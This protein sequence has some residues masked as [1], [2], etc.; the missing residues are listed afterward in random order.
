MLPDNLKVGVESIDARHE[1]FYE[2]FENL[3]NA[4]DSQFLTKF[5]SIIDHTINH[6]AEEEEGLEYPNRSEHRTEHIK[7]LEEMGYFYEKA[8]KGKTVFARAY[9]KEQLGE[10]FRQHLLNMDSD[11]A[12]VKGLV[13]IGSINA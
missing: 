8:K 6:F 11:L 12:R 7:A 5:K 4:S 10:W 13:K 2:L 1:E 9:V 3:K